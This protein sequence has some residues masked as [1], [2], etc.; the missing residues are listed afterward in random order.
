M[1]PEEVERIQRQKKVHDILLELE[2]KSNKRSKSQV[3][4]H[5]I[6]IIKIRQFCISRHGLVNED[7]RRKV[8]PLLLNAEVLNDESSSKIENLKEDTSWIKL[9]KAEHR[10]TDQIGKDIN[11]SLNTFDCCKKWSKSIK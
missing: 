10:D 2:P 7:I 4:N 9:A 8:W 6:D 5:K 1:S 11:R 3:D